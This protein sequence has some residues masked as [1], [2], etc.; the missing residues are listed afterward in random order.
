M[1]R[2]SSGEVT[3]AVRDNPA[4]NRFEMK[5][6]NE[7]AAAYYSRSRSQ[8]LIT[9]TRT[10]VPR[11]LSDRGIGSELAWGALELARLEGLKAIAKCPF[12]A[13]F[14]ALAIS[15]E[16]RVERGLDLLEQHIKGT[17]PAE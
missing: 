3:G 5:V 2:Q 17:R 15:F 16:N 7:V 12:I 11:A 10:V 14:I 9:F 8:G 1:N 6:G 13:A 4:L